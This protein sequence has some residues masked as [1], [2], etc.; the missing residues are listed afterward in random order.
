MRKRFVIEAVMAAIYG[1]LMVPN[2]PVEYLFP[3]S[4]VME[5]Y[6]MKDSSE[7]VMP[8]AGDDAHVKQKISE[9][10]AFF[11]EP[12]N[13]KKIERAFGAPWRLS[14]PLLVNDNV[15]FVVV[16]SM[17]NA[18]YGE[19]FDP[20][21]TELILSSLREQVPI[22]TDQLDFMD[23]VIDTEVPIQVFDIEDFE[24]ALEADEA[25]GDW[26]SP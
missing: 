26:K 6:E 17:E 4:T 20:I 8:E 21:E 13:R 9:M 7:P 12:L 2:R 5:L 25:L 14:P 16:N 1:E 24:Y 10:I 18:Q 3:Y 19:T 11:E 15:S 23:R 22:L